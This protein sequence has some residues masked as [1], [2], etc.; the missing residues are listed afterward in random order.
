MN[1]NRATAKISGSE[2]YPDIYGI[3]CFKESELGIIVEAEVFNLPIGETCSSG[4]FG[5]HIHEGTSCSGDEKDP[6]KDAK[7]HFNPKNCPHPYHAGDLPPLFGNRGYAKMSVL[8]DRFT[9]DEIIGRVIII[10]SMPDDF[11]S[12]PSGNAGEK[13]ACGIIMAE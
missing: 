2:K 3:V 13:I 10:H 4:I 11:T 7:A 8:T 1:K 9:L 6:F 12:Q 5:F